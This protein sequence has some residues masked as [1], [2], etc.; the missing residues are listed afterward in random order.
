VVGTTVR[1]K[2]LDLSC[3]P[4][5][6]ASQNTAVQLA[7]A[8]T[9]CSTNFN[10]RSPTFPLLS[11][12]PLPH[13]ATHQLITIAQTLSPS[14]PRPHLLT[15]PRARTSVSALTWSRLSCHP[16][17]AAASA[18]AP[19]APPAA[20]PA[21]S[22]AAAAAVSRSVGGAVRSV[23]RAESA[24]ARR[25]WA[26]TGPLGLRAGRWVGGLLWVD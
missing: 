23:R 4:F 15:Q 20:A 2:G 9:Q 22:G 3:Q 25:A 12:P 26:A 6:S 19:T 14:C 7:P 17:A 1:A 24:R 16:A 10:H 11:S 18:P 21:S 5:S 13:P 8:P